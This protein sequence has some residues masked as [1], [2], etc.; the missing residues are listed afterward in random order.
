MAG[1]VGLCVTITLMLQGKPQNIGRLSRQTYG[2]N[3]WNF[4]ESRDVLVHS[5]GCLA[6]Q[7]RDSPANSLA[8]TTYPF[9]LS[10]SAPDPT[11]PFAITW[12]HNAMT[13]SS[14]SRINIT[15]NMSTG[16]SQYVIS[17]V[18]YF[19]AGTYQCFGMDAQ[20]QMVSRSAT[21]TLTVQGELAF[22]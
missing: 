11:P 8:L 4:F 18:S 15:Y 13:A 14:D 5:P 1:L 19:D 3:G 10:C 21:G 17:S 9:T 2:R 22:R 20:G 12:L 7:F 6:Q 16:R